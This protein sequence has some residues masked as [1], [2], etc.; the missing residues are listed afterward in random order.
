M[1]DYKK[2]ALVFIAIIALIMVIT[3]P[4]DLY[5]TYDNVKYYPGNDK[6]L[7]SE[8]TDLDSCKIE[9]DN[10]LTSQTYTEDEK[11]VTI[12]VYEGKYIKSWDSNLLVK[13]VFVKGGDGGNL[14]TYEPAEY[15][16]NN[17]SLH[18]PE[19]NEKIPDIS[20]VTFYFQNLGYLELT[21]L[22]E[23]KAPEGEFEI[24][25][26]DE[27]DNI[28]E[29]IN[30]VKGET[31]T[32]ELEPGSYSIEETESNKADSISYSNQDI[33]V[34]EGETIDVTVTNKYEE[35][36]P[37]PGYLTVTKIVE[38]EAPEGTF[39]VTIYDEEENIV[40]VINLVKGESKTIELEPGN[41]SIEETESNKADSISYSNQDIM[42]VEG[43]T[44]DVTVTNKYEK[45]E[46]KPGYLTVTKIV[47]G[48]A[49]EGTFK[50][51][52]YDE[53]ENI[54][55]VI[56]LVKGES[57][58]IELEPGN[59]SIEETE[60]NKADSISYSNQ[61]IMVVEGETIDVTVTNKYEKEEPK[62]GYLTVIKIVEGEA[63][64]GIFK[65]TVY[66]EEEN[67]V[68][69]IELVKGE[70]KKVEL[71]PGSYSIEETD[72][73][74]ADSIS[75]SNQDIMVV[76]GETIDVTVTNKYEEEE[77]IP[78][79]L[80]VT[81][82][83][84]G[85]APE[86]TFKVTIYDEEENIVE[87]IELVK[88]E[89]KKVELE[90]GSY[91]IEETD[92]NKADSI[93][94]SNQDIMVV[95]GETIDVTVTNK[96]EEEEQK[97]G[98]LT[99]T[100]IVEGEASEG[101]FKVTVYDEEENIVEVIE[102]VKGE[103][104]KVELEPGSYS[105]EETDS[106]EAD[107][108]SYSN[109][110]IMVVEGETIDVTVTNKYEEEEP[111]PGYLTVTKIVEGKAPEGEFEVTVYDEE[112]NI[113]EVINL[114]KGESKTI[115]LELG[116]YSIEETESNKAD[117]ISYSNKEFTIEEDK[118]VNL[119]I[120]NLYE[121]QKEDGKD[122]DKNDD[123]DDED[124]KER[125]PGYLTVTKLVEGDTEGKEYEVTIYDEEDNKVEIIEITE[126]TT[127]PI[128]LKIGDYYIVETNNNGADEVEYTKKDFTIIEDETINIT[129][130]N[131]YEEEVIIEPIDEIPD[132]PND[133]EPENEEEII[134]EP[135]KEIPNL[136]NTGGLIPSDFILSGLGTLL[137]G[138]GIK[139]NR[140][141]R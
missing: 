41:Y 125:K 22:V 126:G 43:E 103:T 118:T 4:E 45:E 13:H 80:T 15:S 50:V 11:T 12:E 48:E 26:Y 47:E 51:T 39:K 127:E 93:S 42:V 87:V 68:E 122:E 67:I 115:E 131:I 141:N 59:Y 29:V 76:E 63:P 98:Y 138:F 116:N 82:I 92:S 86:G 32:I 37:K 23:G 27:E 95:E 19:K 69:V 130:T 71:E 14:Y 100:K 52:I 120:K 81:K 40:E 106:N 78:G 121:E 104:K 132:I 73:N 123:K 28:V 53:E 58:T 46:P 108:I 54:V 31:K 83:V 20:H 79:Y 128:K 18:S 112:E 114:V 6:D 38:G 35:E 89:T 85:E 91:S 65:V 133:P 96:Y 10:L 84:E 34:V 137:L 97:P 25:V 124:N 61:D 33:M 72:S 117:S 105:I 62:P 75:Y 70:T 139:L 7:S 94:Y 36:E 55:E 113:V 74:K 30:I 90:P 5:A 102:L 21:K 88:G 107:S 60:S 24:T 77:P 111:K 56:N 129:I 135:K 1:K 101:I 140:K 49:P 110:D 17:I 64:E 99:V 9:A 57:K 119:T 44:I 3:L 109:Q 8:V 16:D 136:P 66:D 134:I 2:R